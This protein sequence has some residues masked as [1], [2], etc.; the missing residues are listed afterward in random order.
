MVVHGTDNGRRESGLLYQ[1]LVPVRVGQ[2]QQ[3]LVEE[4]GF[5]YSGIGSRP[6]VSIWS[7]VCC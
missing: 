1:G 5:R 3:G 6:R 7:V 2:G 4:P